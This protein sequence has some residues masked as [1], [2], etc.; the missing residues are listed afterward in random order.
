MKATLFVVA[1]NADLTQVKALI[2]MLMG[3]NDP[4]NLAR[5]TA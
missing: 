5:V 2:Q 3:W 1:N 4:L